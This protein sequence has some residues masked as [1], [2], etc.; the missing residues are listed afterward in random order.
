M[1][2]Y[3]YIAIAVLAELKLLF[4]TFRVTRIFLILKLGITNRT[5][6]IR[7]PRECAFVWLWLL[8]YSVLAIIA[9]AQGTAW[10]IEHGYAELAWV[11]VAVLVTGT[12]VTLS[13]SHALSSTAH[14][15][16]QKYLVFTP[17]EPE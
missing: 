9:G 3:L 12:A 4:D 6:Q 16:Y 2:A 7:L 13:R 14:R 5:Y 11:A 10:L 15:I 1:A 8:G 17:P